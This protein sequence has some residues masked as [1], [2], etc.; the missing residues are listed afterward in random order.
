MSGWDK[1]PSNQLRETAASTMFGVIPA[2]SRETA[3]SW[4]D[5]ELVS[6]HSRTES[7][8]RDRNIQ[9]YTR[10]EISMK[11]RVWNTI[12]GFPHNKRHS[13]EAR[14]SKEVTHMVRH[15]DQD[16]REE[17][18]AMHWD[19]ILPKLRK[20]FQSQL[21][22]ECANKDWID[23]LYRGSYKT[24]FEIC[25]DADGELV[26]IRS[27][28]GHSGGV[29]ELRAESVQVEAIHLSHR[30]RERPI[31]HCG[32]WTG[33]RRKS[34][35]RRKTDDFF[36]PL[37]PFHMMPAKQKQLQISQNREKYIIKVIGDLNKM[38]CTG[39]TCPQHKTTV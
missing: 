7:S 4:N 17:D 28:Q 36:T 25:K 2:S 35:Q 30:S 33:G 12:A 11:D 19:A 34:K 15:R 6:I 14:I 24:R 22:K 31:F 16:E 1:K 27:I 23:Y 39:L 9:I 10:K 8:R 38:L 21:D 18:G 20:K 26:Y 29:A 5:S 3:A 13:I 32:S 37:D